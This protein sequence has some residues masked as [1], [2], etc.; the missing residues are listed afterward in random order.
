M[1]FFSASMMCAD[2]AHLENEVQ[3]LEEAGIDYYH[4]DVMDGQF[5]HNF[6]MGV[7]DIQLIA[8]L[9]KRPL[10]MHLM[11]ERPS[12]YIDFFAKLGGSLIYIH[13]ESE[14]QPATTLEIIADLGLEAGLVISPNTSVESVE[15]FFYTC[16]N[17]LLMGVN[18][19]HAG[20]MYLP[21]I[22]KKLNKLLE[23]K[24]EYG[25]SIEM[26]GACT[27]ERICAWNALGVDGYVL[28]TAGLFN[29]KTQSDPAKY[30]NV[31]DELRQL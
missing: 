14:R 26:D 20:Q 15:G 12:R 31:L 5:V 27:A 3:L 2:Y 1:S 11:I 19:G 10:E 18:P 4:I 25:L 24:E 22:D 9:T 28:G 23:I 16:K 17:I 21:Y 30:K 7:Q 6:G 8:S 29:Q 13:P